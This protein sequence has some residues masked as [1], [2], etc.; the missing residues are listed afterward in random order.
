MYVCTIRKSS[1]FPR[2]KKR[3]TFR[4]TLYLGKAQKKPINYTQSKSNTRKIIPVYINCVNSTLH[5]YCRF[6]F[7]KNQNQQITD[8]YSGSLPV[9][10]G[11]FALAQLRFLFIGKRIIRVTVPLFIRKNRSQ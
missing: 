5:K 9:L 8:F 6:I 1:F 11:D 10:A 7:P 2:E 4:A 3:M